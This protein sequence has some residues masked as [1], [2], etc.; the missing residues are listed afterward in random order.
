ML[1]DNLEED[2]HRSKEGVNYIQDRN[3]LVVMCLQPSFTFFYLLSASHHPP[4]GLSLCSPHHPYSIRSFLAIPFF[5]L[6]YPCTHTGVLGLYT[7]YRDP[8]HAYVRIRTTGKIFGIIPSRSLAGATDIALA[9]VSTKIV[10]IAIGTGIPDALWL[11]GLSTCFSN[12]GVKC[13]GKVGP[14]I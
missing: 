14:T 13:G 4:R 6:P 1:S 10:A 9:H 12:C 2:P 8:V 5:T 11:V 7:E 3:Q